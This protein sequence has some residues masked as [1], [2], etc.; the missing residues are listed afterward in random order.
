[1]ININQSAGIE[2]FLSHNAKEEEKLKV[3]EYWH[4]NLSSQVDEFT[5]VLQLALKSAEV[6]G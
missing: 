2:D 6:N 1:M 3:W 5:S 4:Q